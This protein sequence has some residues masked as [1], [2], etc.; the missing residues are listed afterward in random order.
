MS[1]KQRVEER[2]ALSADSAVLAW[3]PSLFLLPLGRSALIFATQFIQEQFLLTGVSAVRLPSIELLRTK[4]H[5]LPRVAPFDADRPAL[6]CFHGHPSHLYSMIP[7]IVP[8][9]NKVCLS[10]QSKSAPF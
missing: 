10:Q 2:T 5:A 6:L 3:N 7:D 8:M 1:A 4:R 9:L